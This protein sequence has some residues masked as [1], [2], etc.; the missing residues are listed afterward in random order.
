[1]KVSYE[2][3]ETICN[4]NSCKELLEDNRVK[5]FFRHQQKL[6]ACTG[7]VSSGKE[8][9]IAA[10][11]YEAIPLELK[12]NYPEE[13]FTKTER[14]YVGREFVYKGKPMLML[15]PAQEVRPKGK[16]EKQLELF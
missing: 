4:L 12:L 10:T 3:M 9:W 15:G 8:G 13:R 7:T 2:F 6:F 1:M 5:G 16:A 14:G 11:I